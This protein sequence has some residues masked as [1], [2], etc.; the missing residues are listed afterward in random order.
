[1]TVPTME[2]AD[3]ELEAAMEEAE[4][5]WGPT[6]GTH[7]LPQ[8]ELLKIRIE[9]GEAYVKDH[10]QEQ[11]PKQLLLKLR[12]RLASA[13]KD[14]ADIKRCERWRKAFERFEKAMERCESFGQKEPQKEV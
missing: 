10:P 12:Q 1:M 9:L 6:D 11:G 8:A 2:E 5:A 14:P 4:A 3:A 7:A 13:L